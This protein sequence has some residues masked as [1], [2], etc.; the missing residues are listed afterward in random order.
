M[1]FITFLCLFVALGFI[2]YK[3]E[4]A[5]MRKKGIGPIC[6]LV[7]VLALV[8]LMR[9][10]P[11]FIFSQSNALPASIYYWGYTLMLAIGALV[12]AALFVHR[13][14][15]RPH[16]RSDLAVFQSIYKV[17]L[18]LGFLAFIAN[19]AILLNYGIVSAMR[20]LGGFHKY[21]QNASQTEENTITLLRTTLNS[22][23]FSAFGLALLS[24]R[25]HSNAI[26]KL[27][28][29][30]VVGVLL[31][32]LIYGGRGAFVITVASIACSA[33]YLGVYRIKFKT[34][35]RIVPLAVVMGLVVYGATLRRLSYLGPEAGRSLM[36]MTGASDTRIPD[37]VMESPVGV[38]AV[39]SYLYFASPYN[40][41]LI[42]FQNQDMFELSYGMRS[43][44]FIN[45]IMDRV[46]PD[47]SMR[48]RETHRGN[49]DVLITR[50]SGGAAQWPTIYGYFL[51]DFGVKGTLLACLCYGSLLGAL[52]AFTG[53]L[54]PYVKLLPT[55][56]CFRFALTSFIMPM[57]AMRNEFLMLIG[58]FLIALFLRPRLPWLGRPFRR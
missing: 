15:F 4:C 52:S 32:L 47:F 53:D 33:L 9:H 39:Q 37:A 38:F 26:R 23:Q 22:A 35:L 34:I 36:A 13:V 54:T 44:R 19:F 10:L 3:A 17:L 45:V 30:F 46:F 20:D 14:G 8:F 12:T 11:V 21:V 58:A 28:V 56:V 2:T 25:V 16:A 6:M 48:Q 7:C 42:T 18:T 5:I 29:V 43:I 31:Q 24:F 1:I 41:Y 27:T 51:T 57:T 50:F 40:K 49:V 55:I